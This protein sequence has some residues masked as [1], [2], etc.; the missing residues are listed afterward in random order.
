[1]GTAVTPDQLKSL[2]QIVSGSG[3]P[4]EVVLC[5]DSDAAG[6]DAT[7]R[8]LET[9]WQQFGTKLTGS[10]NRDIR[11]RV[12]APVDGKDPDEAIR[13]DSW[14][15]RRSLDDATP[16]I[17]FIMRAYVSRFDVSSG[18][19]KVK[20]IEKLSPLIFA[21][22]NDYDRDAFWEQ[23][24][25]LLE[26]STERLRS[27]TPNPGTRSR[28]TGR[29]GRGRRGEAI[30]T[31]QMSA[32]LSG[33]LTGIEEHV[34]ALVFQHPEL[35]EFAEAIPEEH[36]LDTVNRELFTT[37]VQIPTLDEMVA[38]L[39]SDLADNAVRLAAVPAPPSDHGTR[40]TEITQCARRLRE[41]YLRNLLKLTEIALK[42]EE[43]SL[44][45]EELSRLRSEIL[46]P[47]DHLKKVFEAGAT[48]RI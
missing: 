36:F 18:D 38:A 37:W 40:V 24:A 32:A 48:G 27:M 20:V 8:A 17:D 34:L 2:S 12:A 22:S 46:G 21:V 31:E 43:G 23:L 42:E 3:E 6:Q 26:V 11:V 5:L 29:G 28:N 35:R 15:W 10:R 44:E 16:L 9:A 45:T 1:M 19:G 13:A 30:S 47:S 39:S 41:R 14:A 4:G 7:L 33:G 25:G